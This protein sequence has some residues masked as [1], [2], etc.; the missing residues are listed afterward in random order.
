M[1]IELWSHP[2]GLVVEVGSEARVSCLVV[3]LAVPQHTYSFLLLHLTV[4]SPVSLL[5]ADA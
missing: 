2:V 4:A 1:E 5:L 3:A